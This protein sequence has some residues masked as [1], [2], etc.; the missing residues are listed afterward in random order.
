MKIVFLDFDGVLISHESFKRKAAGQRAEPTPESVAA[1]NHLFDTTDAKVVVSSVWRLGRPSGWLQCVL[2]AWGVRAKIIGET[3]ELDR[4]DKSNGLHIARE[5]GEEIACWLRTHAE[6]EPRNPE[7]DV[8]GFV[9]V[10]DDSD[11]AHL[12]PYLVQTNFDVGF[13]MGD[14]RHAIE[15]LNGKAASVDDTSPT[16][17]M[18]RL[19]LRFALSVLRPLR[20]CRAGKKS[21]AAVVE[22]LKKAR[23]YLDRYIAKLEK[24]QP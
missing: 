16:L 24:E 23:W 9:I 22:D 10:D 6:R 3:P 2:D 14:A 4:F 18:V 20:S 13:T 1:L 11:M 15:I 21:T 17:P 8:H 12:K 19:H 7:E 5:R